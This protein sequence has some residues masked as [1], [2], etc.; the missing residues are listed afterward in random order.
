[1]TACLSAD[2]IF[3]FESCIGYNIRSYNVDYRRNADAVARSHP[4]NTAT[5]LLPN[6]QLFAR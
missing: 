3:G 6:V 4:V 5:L 2:M 1:M